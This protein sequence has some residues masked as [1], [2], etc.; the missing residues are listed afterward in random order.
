[1]AG[2]TCAAAVSSVKGS[3]TLLAPGFDRP[4]QPLTGSG[5]RQPVINRGD[6]GSSIPGEKAVSVSSPTNQKE[7]Q[8]VPDDQL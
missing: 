1:M 7:C 6:L 3:L 5:Q 8:E 2:H 4:L